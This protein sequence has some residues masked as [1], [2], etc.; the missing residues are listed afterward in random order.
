M[1]ELFHIQDS[2]YDYIP[3]PTSPV[4]ESSNFV[5]SFHPKGFTEEGHGYCSAVLN[6]INQVL[7]KDDE[8]DDDEMNIKIKH[9]TLE[10]E[11][12]S[13]YEILNQETCSS[14]E[15]VFEVE[16]DREKNQISVIGRKHLHQ[17]D[18]DNGRLNKHRLTI[19][20]DEEEPVLIE[21]F[22]KVLVLSIEDERS[23][24]STHS[25]TIQHGQKGV[26]KRE[27]V[28]MRNLLIQCMQTLANNDQKTAS[29]LLEQI[30]QRSSPIGDG[31]QRLAY[32]FADGIEARLVRYGSPLFKDGVGM[33]HKTLRDTTLLKACKMYLSVIPFTNTI[34]ALATGLIMDIARKRRSKLHVIHFGIVPGFQLIPLIQRLSTRDGDD[35]DG[36]RPPKLRVTGIDFPQAGFRPTAKIDETG[37]RLQSYC[38]KFGVEFEYDSV[39]ANWEK[40]TVSDLKIREDEIVVVYCLFHSMYL[41]DESILEDSPR[42]AVLKLIRRINPEIFIH[43]IVNGNLNS[44][45]FDSRFRE[46]L[47][48]FSTMFDMFDTVLPRDNEERMVFERGI[49]GEEILNTVACEGEERKERPE[50]YKQW[51]V[52][53][54]RAGFRQVPLNEEMVKKQKAIVKSRYHKDFFVEAANEWMLQGWK[55]RALCAISS[56]KPA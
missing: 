30:R 32:Y 16:F 55:G 54:V 37:R 53:T 15:N 31:S 22:D 29:I 28:G 40:I 38:E 48:H 5:D 43:G 13:F 51:H 10:Q 26:H 18:D 20:T 4:P 25:K 35:D 1:G 17:E 49:L 14:S 24:E 50:T 45:F 36:G 23:K 39:A 9:P 21:M 42:D 27:A 7:M 34:Y 8:D 2:P 6:Y 44:P 12:K 3:D 52:R 56:W 47:F 41:L 33:Y 46:A 11:E 19:H